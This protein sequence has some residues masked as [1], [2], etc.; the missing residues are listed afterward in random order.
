MKNEIDFYK[1]KKWVDITKIQWCEL[2]KS[3]NYNTLCFIEKHIDILD[4]DCLKKLSRNPFAIHILERNI[5]KINWNSFVYNPNCMNTINKNIDICF[6]SLN[7]RGK[8]GLLQHPHFICILHENYDKIIHNFICLSSIEFFTQTSNPIYIDLLDKY[9]EIHSEKIEELYDDF[10]YE[11]SSN[12]NALKIIEKHLDKIDKHCWK[13]LARNPKAIHIIE[14]NLDKFEYYIWR[15]LCMNP[16]AIHI[17]KQNIHKLD[18]MSWQYLSLNE[19][20]IAFGLRA[21]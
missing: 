9:L 16:N 21:K 17:I 13:A 10:W 8:I 11:L 5:D 19:N 2:V 14:N 6:A 7:W 15:Y 20:G 1:V 18:R 12:S 4:N 3:P